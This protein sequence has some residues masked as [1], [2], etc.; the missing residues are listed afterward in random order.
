SPEGIA[1]T[2]LAEAVNR[3]A[4]E[5]SFELRPPAVSR[6]FEK[7]VLGR[8]VKHTI[9]PRLVYRDVTG[10]N[11]FPE[12]IRFDARD[13]MTDTNELEYALTNRIYLKNQPG[14]NC[15]KPPPAVEK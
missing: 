11:N 15:P 10:I 13:I 4:L 7:P 6:I 3:H 1:G 8:K 9:E 14:K 5:S 2:P 12:I